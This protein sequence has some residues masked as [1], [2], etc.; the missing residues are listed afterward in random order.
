MTFSQLMLS[1]RQ[2]L[3]ARGMS[4]STS[5]HSSK[6]SWQ[7]DSTEAAHHTFC[8]AVKWHSCLLLHLSR[9]RPC[10]GWM[11]LVDGVVK[12]NGPL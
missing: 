2:V 1:V 10:G 9:T 11:L 8:W 7:V 3:C 4:W 5:P 6:G 12:F